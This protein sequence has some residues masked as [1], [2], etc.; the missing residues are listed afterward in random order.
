MALTNPLPIPIPSN[1]ISKSK[2]KLGEILSNSFLKNNQNDPEQ[3]I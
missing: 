2:E 1:L 3:N